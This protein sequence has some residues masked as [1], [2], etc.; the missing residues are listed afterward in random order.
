MMACENVLWGVRSSQNQFNGVNIQGKQ[1]LSGKESS[2]MT[3]HKDA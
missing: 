2:K 3:F 1:K